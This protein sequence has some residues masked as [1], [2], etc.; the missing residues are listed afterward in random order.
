MVGTNAL[1]L[2]AKT[3]PDVIS[4]LA[5]TVCIVLALISKQ[6]I[7]EKLMHE[8]VHDLKCTVCPQ[9]GNKDLFLLNHTEQKDTKN[10]KS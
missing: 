10:L 3:S 2:F 7:W 1:F 9:Q 8:L 5:P 4:C 6:S